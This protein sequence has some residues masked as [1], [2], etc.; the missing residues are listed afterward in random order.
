MP[1]K[2]QIKL[3]LKEAELYERQG[4][5][6]QSTQIYMN[7]IESIKKD[8]LLSQ[9]TS[10]L[11]EIDNKL[12]AVDDKM[13]EVEEATDTPVLSEDIQNLISNLFSFSKNKQVAAIEG[14][15][16]LAK[17]G[18]YEKALAEF[19]RLINE[20]ILPIMAAKNM[21]RCQLTLSS[22]DT[23]IGQYEKWLSIKIFNN[24]ELNH[25]REFLGNLLR[26]EGIKADLPG[27]IEDGPKKWTKKDSMEDVFE[28]SSIRVRLESGPL[29][30]Q[31]NDFD[32]TF[33]IGNTVS[34]IIKAHS[35]LLLESL[36]PGDK[37]SRVQCYS[38]LSLF[39]CT[40]IVS[41]KS[42]ILSGPK[43]GDYTLDITIDGES[44]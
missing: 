18:Q 32:V 38:P 44:N 3:K 2:E 36:N 22:P 7:L 8:S 37:L 15:V 23:A 40:G 17:F 29:K 5:Y 14:A 10:L 26:K 19:Q 35:Q 21:L 41:E 31:E 43:K 33:Q 13:T 28:I 24:A 42:K 16:A 39:N 25:L 9:D 6:K 11:T 1:T 12:K 20:G 30:G 4:L 27:I 34:L